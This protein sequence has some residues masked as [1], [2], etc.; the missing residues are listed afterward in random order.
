MIPNRKSRGI[1]RESPPQIRQA[2]RRRGGEA[3]LQKL[4]AHFFFFA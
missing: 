4:G 3:V 1:A 2:I